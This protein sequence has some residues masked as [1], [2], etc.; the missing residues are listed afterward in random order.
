[1][2]LFHKECKGKLTLDLSQVLTVR[3]RATSVQSGGLSFGVLE[4]VPR[5]K[6]GEI[7]LSCGKCGGT[8]LLSNPELVMGKCPVCRKERSVDRL[9]QDESFPIIC[10]DCASIING[11]KKPTATISEIVSFFGLTRKI[12]GTPIMKLLSNPI[13]F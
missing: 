13:K 6:P 12:S 7:F 10:E 9:I 11:E 4:I 3:T 2:E 5:E 8:V 1:M